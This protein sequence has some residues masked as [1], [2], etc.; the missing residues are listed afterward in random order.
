M[1]LEYNRIGLVES[2]S[3]PKAN[4]FIVVSNEFVAKR[5]RVQT[6]AAVTTIEKLEF[7]TAPYQGQLVLLFDEISQSDKQKVLN[8]VAE[9]SNRICFKAGWQYVI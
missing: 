8:F 1:F 6:S 7:D 4:I 5:L 3:I 9:N 2:R